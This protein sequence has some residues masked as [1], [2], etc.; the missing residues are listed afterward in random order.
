[1]K[2]TLIIDLFNNFS[3][4]PPLSNIFCKEDKLLMENK[5]LIVD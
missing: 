1:M 4:Q 3:N 2:R 5:L